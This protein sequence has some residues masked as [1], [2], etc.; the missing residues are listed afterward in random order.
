MAL[1]AGAGAVVLALLAA[2]GPEA[3]EIQMTADE[4]GATQVR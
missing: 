1:V 3:R 4:D 2:F